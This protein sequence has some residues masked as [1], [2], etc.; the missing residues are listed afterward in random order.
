MVNA[1]ERFSE[2]TPEIL[3]LTDEC[4]KNSSIQ[5]EMYTKYKV[6]RGLR[7]LN[8][9]RRAHRADGNLGNPVEQKIR[10]PDHSL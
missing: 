9:Q 1:D 6:N 2:I 8:G 5:P 4:L 3:A 7:D 10:G